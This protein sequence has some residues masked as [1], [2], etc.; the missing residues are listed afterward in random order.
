MSDS[1]KRTEPFQ[2]YC[3]TQ[4][5]WERVEQT[6][7][8]RHYAHEGNPRYIES[9]MFCPYISLR[10]GQ[11]KFYD[12]NDCPVKS[13]DWSADS[14]DVFVAFQFRTPDGIS[15]PILDDVIKP[16][17]RG[18]ELSA[19]A[20]TDVEYNEGI[21]DEILK[22]IT[23]SRFVIAD[24]TYNNNGAYYEAGYAKGQGKKVIHTCSKDWFDKNGVHFDVGGLNLVLY[25]NDEDFKTKLRKRIQETFM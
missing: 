19:F 24:L 22:S 10:K 9:S 23:K 14:A 4:N 15:R 18:F 7:L 21:Y 16:I 13:G 12:N 6:Y 11:C 25:E 1:E 2:G 17:C 3:P 20:I 8:I 5:K